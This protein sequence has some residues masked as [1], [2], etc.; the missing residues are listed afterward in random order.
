[1]VRLAVNACPSGMIMTDAGGKIVL[2]NAEVER[3]FA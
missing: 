1:M 2:F 3:L